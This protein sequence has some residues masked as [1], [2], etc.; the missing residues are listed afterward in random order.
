MKYAQHPK[1]LRNLLSSTS[2]IF[3]FERAFLI[4]A[5]LG[6]FGSK[7]LRFVSPWGEVLKRMLSVLIPNRQMSLFVNVLKLSSM[8]LATLGCV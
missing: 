1:A 4:H 6:Y 5:R 7:R 8:K 2:S 3:V